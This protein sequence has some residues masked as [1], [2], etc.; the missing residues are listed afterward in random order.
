M[1]ET[2][3]EYAL[4]RLEASAE[5][6]ELR[7]RHAAHFL[8]LAEEAEPNL[9][10][11]PKEWLD[12]LEPEH[13]NLRAALDHLE[14]AGE[15]QLVLRLASALTNFWALRGHLAEGRRRVEDALVADERPTIARANALNAAAEFAGFTGDLEIERSLAEE[16]LALHTEL[17]NE[18]GSAFSR[19]QLASVA[20]GERDWATAKKLMEQSVREFDEL[21][22]DFHRLTARRGLAWMHEEL[23]DLVRYR[24]LTEENLRLARSLGNRR[25]EARAL[26][27]LAMVAL[28]EGRA[29]EALEMLR[30]S[31]RIDRDL[32]N[33]IF[34]GIDLA[35]F[36]AIR[37]HE[38][39]AEAA[40]QLLA[41][42]TAMHE[43]V[44]WT[45]ESWAAEESERTRASVY[46]QL[47]EAVFA[48][49]WERGRRLTLDEA[50]TLAL[51][52]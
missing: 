7:R 8:A 13:D 52:S 34:I 3:R 16:A 24:E 36:A 17:G 19:Y 22:D 30:E 37:G 38:G 31:L 29:Q 44:D 21:G 35:R 51:E 5:A 45:P 33:V 20:G 50:V 49:A 48:A 32:G 9:R 39:K 4:E 27:A 1:L 26:G 46:S 28:D 47:E 18:W 14:A 2:I 10:G 15:T 11:D 25:I 43:E 41:K 12:R 23:G 40:A 6:A 42:S